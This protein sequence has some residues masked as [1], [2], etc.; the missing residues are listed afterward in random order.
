MA[1]MSEARN[2]RFWK[3][4]GDGRDRI[5]QAGRSPVVSTVPAATR[6]LGDVTNGSASTQAAPGTDGRSMQK[7]TTPTARKELFGE[8][9]AEKGKDPVPD[10]G[11]DDFPPLWSQ[12]AGTSVQT[13]KEQQEPVLPNDAGDRPARSNAWAM[14]IP[15]SA[16][17]GGRQSAAGVE[18]YNPTASS[19]FTGEPSGSK[20]V[21]D[22]FTEIRSKRGRNADREHHQGSKDIANQNPFAALI[23]T[24]AEDIDQQLEGAADMENLRE[25]NGGQSEVRE[26]KINV[27]LKTPSVNPAVIIDS[28]PENSTAERIDMTP[29]MDAVLG[30]TPKE[31]QAHPGEELQNIEGIVDT[32][33]NW[34]D[35]A[36]KADAEMIVQASRG[37]K[38]RL[39]VDEQHT[40]DRGNVRRED[41]PGLRRTCSS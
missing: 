4:L 9:N 30:L 38:G 5:R 10:A 40:P 29:P 34:A 23:S 27:E 24:E 1:T 39:P 35:L 28:Q 36:E 6:T 33:G 21:E 8:L 19:G 14:G 13:L 16:P 15:R 25:M 2:G 32:V 26:E 20:T 3:I 17:A 31:A 41:I 7:T 11:I 37:V 22:G 12:R 18:E